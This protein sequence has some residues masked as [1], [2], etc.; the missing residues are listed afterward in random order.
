VNP[1][2]NREKERAALD[3]FQTA[4]TNERAVPAGRNVSARSLSSREGREIRREGKG[5]FRPPPSI[6]EKAIRRPAQRLYNHRAIPG[7][8]Y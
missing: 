6:F 1:L 3:V 7:T 4:V 2:G 5:T 8:T